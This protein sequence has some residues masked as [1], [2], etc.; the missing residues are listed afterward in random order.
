MEV[1][2]GGSGAEAGDGD[3]SG[4]ELFGECFGEGEDVG[5]AGEVGG[6]EGSGDEGGGAGYVEDV[7][8]GA[9]EHGR[10]EA[11]GE[12]GEGPDVEVEHFEVLAEGGFFEGAVVG[13]GGVIDEGFDDE[14]LAEGLSCDFGGGGGVGEVGGDGP[15][16]DLEVLADVL[17][18]LFEFVGVSGVE[19]EGVAVGGKD[20]GE[21]ES[22]A[23]GGSGDEGEMPGGVFGHGLAE[24][25][26]FQFAEFSRNDST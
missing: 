13:E 25:S 19:D 1:G 21:G 8:V 5:F 9:V 16:F 22:D 7:A 3:A 15:D 20:S 2:A 11:M 4:V 26:S 24:F 6:H 23:A 18:G 17:G 14:A 10:G 12:L